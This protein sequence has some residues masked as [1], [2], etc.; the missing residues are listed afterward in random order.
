MRR[1]WDLVQE[2]LEAYEE[3]NPFNHD[4]AAAKNIDH[5]EP[6]LVY[7]HIA[8][9][10]EQ[11]Y[12]DSSLI[13]HGNLDVLSGMDE[14]LNDETVP[15]LLTWKGHDLLDDLRSEENLPESPSSRSV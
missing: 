4:T 13:E 15:L 9:L 6:E 2:I 11:G 12:L 1:D 8:M 3:D 5:D 7:Y 10:E 14:Q